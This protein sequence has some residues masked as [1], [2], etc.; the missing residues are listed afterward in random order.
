VA[1]G[2]KTGK[3]AAALDSRAAAVRHL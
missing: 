2:A 1:G 3:E